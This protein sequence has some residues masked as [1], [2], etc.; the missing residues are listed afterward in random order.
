MNNNAKH[1]RDYRH[2]YPEKAKAHAAIRQKIKSGKLVAQPCSKCNA[3]P[4]QAHHED[5]GK[6]FD[7]IWLCQP[8]HVERHKELA[9][10]DPEKW[11]QYTH[12]KAPQSRLLRPRVRKVRPLKKPQVFKRDNLQPKAFELRGQGCTYEAIAVS[13]SVTKGTVYKWLNATVYK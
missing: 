10:L 2:R 9:A 3:T 6:P 1:L 11:G 12:G 4:T 13:L 7:I 5:Y 8:C